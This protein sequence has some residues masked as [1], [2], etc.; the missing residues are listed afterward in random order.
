MQEIPTEHH[1]Q[2]RFVQ[3][4]RRQYPG[5]KIFAI[6]NGGGRSRGEG[7]RLK[8]EGVLPGVPDLHIPTRRLWIEMKRIKGGSVSADQ[9]KML[10]YLNNI[11][12]TTAVV[13]YGCDAAIRE[14]LSRE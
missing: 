5:E 8:L 3:W 6:P 4:F 13:C 14:V 11:P 2:V 1:E 9:Q 10:D 12:G 7:S